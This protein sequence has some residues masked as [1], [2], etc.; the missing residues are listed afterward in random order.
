MHDISAL[1][2]SNSAVGVAIDGDGFV[3]DEK[4]KDVAGN[5]NLNANINAM[6]SDPMLSSISNLTFDIIINLF[7]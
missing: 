6:I 3:F 5:A 7:C 1:S 4:S 2:I